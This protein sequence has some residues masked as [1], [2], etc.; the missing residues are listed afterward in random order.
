MT[1]DLTLNIR[2]PVSQKSGCELER[3]DSGIKPRASTTC[4]APV[5]CRPDKIHHGTAGCMDE[6]RTAAS[7]HRCQR[8]IHMTS[9]TTTMD[10][11]VA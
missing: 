2:R 11:A 8:Y 9:T 10:T 6:K 1:D 3:M 7:Q 5:F 4:E